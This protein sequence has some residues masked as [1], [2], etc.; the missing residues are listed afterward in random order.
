ML[1][2]IAATAKS[3]G[4]TTTSEIDSYVVF[5]YAQN[6]WYNG[7]LVRT[8]WID[9]VAFTEYPVAA[10]TD[11]NLYHHEL[12]H[13]DGSTTPFSAVSA[14]AESSI[15]E[16]I[17]GDGYQ[18]AFVRRL[19]PDVTFGNST[20]TSPAVV[21][22]I[23]PRDYP[24]QAEGTDD[25]STITRTGTEVIGTSVEEYTEQ[26]HIR[27]RGRALRY[28]IENS[29]TEIFWRDGTPRLEV[30]PDGRQ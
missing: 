7:T 14:H 30:R 17:P 28:R 3:G 24:G 21:I 23:T 12:G 4:S 18:Y 19:I 13:D 27:V 15:F 10:Y 29:G 6:I 16:A 26:A 22:T 20:A 25:A 9:R 5:N 1:A 8:A 2:S 11:G